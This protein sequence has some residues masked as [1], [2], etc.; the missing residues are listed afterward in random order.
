MA[1]IRVFP[2]DDASLDIN[3]D[4]AYTVEIGRPGFRVIVPV[5]IDH[6]GTPLTIGAVLDAVRGCWDGVIGDGVTIRIEPATG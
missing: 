4:G 3:M 5:I 6:S 1:T 2:T